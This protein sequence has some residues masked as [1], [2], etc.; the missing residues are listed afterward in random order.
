ML[1][2]I[3][4]YNIF[5]YTKSKKWYFDHASLPDLPYQGNLHKYRGV[6]KDGKK[7][8]AVWSDIQNE[9][10]CDEV[11]DIPYE[12]KMSYKNT[13]YPTQKPQELLERL[14]KLSCPQNGKILDPFVGSGT[15]M[16]TAQ[17]LGRNCIGIDANKDAIETTRNSLFQQFPNANL[18]VHSLHEHSSFSS[19]HIARKN[20]CEQN[21]YKKTTSPITTT[22]TNE[23]VLFAPLTRPCTSLDI[24]QLTSRYQT[25]IKKYPKVYLLGF[26]FPQI[27]IDALN[28][29]F[30]PIEIAHNPPFHIQ[31]TQNG[32]LIRIHDVQI[33]DLRVRLGADE[34]IVWQQ[35]ISSIRIQS[36]KT[37]DRVY[38]GTTKEWVPNAIS[39]ETTPS[40]I[41][42]TDILSRSVSITISSKP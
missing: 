20:I 15:T 21:K 25:E 1:F 32:N 13:G 4:L 6:Q 17:K 29:K 9:L 22:S 3:F 36:Q 27:S 38:I 10:P 33:P 8:T 12:N 16:R 40:V 11:W 41:T 2:D 35:L 23:L 39:V 31:W 42:F 37:S 7:P 28:E 14:I 26:S 24:E 30:T 18:I 34:S 5:L 19:E